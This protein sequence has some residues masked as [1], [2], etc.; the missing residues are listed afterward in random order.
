M[1]QESTKAQFISLQNLLG[2][3][4]LTPRTT[5]YLT[6]VTTLLF[7]A[8]HDPDPQAPQAANNSEAYA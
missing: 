6:Q 8:K 4:S 3:D 2:T 7:T 1:T 5:Q